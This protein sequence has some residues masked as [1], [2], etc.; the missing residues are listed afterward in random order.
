MKRAA[1]FPFVFLT[2][3]YAIAAG[4]LYAGWA[5]WYSDIPERVVVLHNLV[6]FSVVLLIVLAGVLMAVIAGVVVMYN[7]NFINKTWLAVYIVAPIP[8]G[9]MLV[10]MFLL[11]ALR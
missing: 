11:F 9:I 7:L 4:F 1:I 6:N 8:I 2:A 5:T 10:E 3:L